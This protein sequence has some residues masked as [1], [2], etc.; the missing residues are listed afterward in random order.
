MTVATMVLQHSCPGASCPGRTRHHLVAV[1][2]AALLVHQ[3][4]AVSVAS[5][6]TPTSYPPEPRRRPVLQVGGAAV[7]VDVDAV[8]G[9]VD[10]VRVGLEGGRRAPARVALAAPLAQSTR[11]FS[12]ARSDST[13]EATKS[14]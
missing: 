1:D 9:V 8:G 5:K 14:I 6:A 7:A 2:G 13:V 12:P 11:I 4:A 3:Q 10:E